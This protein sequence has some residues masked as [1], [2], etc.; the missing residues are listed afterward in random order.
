MRASETDQSMPA[1][2]SSAPPF[3]ISSPCAVFVNVMALHTSKT[4]WGSDAL[5]YNPSRWINV[6]SG[7][8]V[9][10][11]KRTYIPWSTG[12]RSCSGQKMSQVEFV[13]VISTLFG[14][15][16]AEPMVE[17]GESVQDG[18]EIG[19]GDGR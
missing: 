10:P 12:P 8:L 15:C 14:K 19:E 6:D 2:D 17:N 13:A 9:K 16:N 4:T 5:E 1:T 11:P 7:Q 18:R 3:K